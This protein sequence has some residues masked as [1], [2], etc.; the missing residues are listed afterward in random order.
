MDYSCNTVCYAC[1][2]SS[3]CTHISSLEG[4]TKKFIPEIHTIL[5]LLRLFRIINF[6]AEVKAFIF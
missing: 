5:L 2:Y 1:K 6:F 4:V 3:F